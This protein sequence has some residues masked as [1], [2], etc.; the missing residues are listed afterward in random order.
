MSHIHIPDGILPVW[1][2]LLGYAAVFLLFIIFKITADKDKISKKLAL[3]G[4]FS[5]LM[6]LSMSFLI[7]PPMYHLNLVALTGI[8]IG[9]YLSLV[10]IFIVNL[11][12][13][14]AGHGGITIVGLNT[15]VLFLQ[16]VIAF[17]GFRFLSRLFKN[18][19]ISVF[20]AAFIALIVSTCAN[21]AIVYIGT[22]NMGYIT[23]VHH[24]HGFFTHDDEHGEEHEHGIQEEH[25]HSEK[26]ENFD[27]RKFLAFLLTFGSVGLITES[28][29]TGFIVSYINRV[30]PEVLNYENN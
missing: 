15:L 1:L 13:A 2:W 5:A 6:I 27:M 16:A 18:V 22:Q 10:S 21:A 24:H 4:T 12:L 20:L 19:F 14:L 9:P 8:V 7:I 17:Y 26:P 29:L 28:L 30:K 11:L 23:H 25:E 3:A